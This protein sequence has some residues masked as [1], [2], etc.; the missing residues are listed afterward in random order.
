MLIL[1]LLDSK[2]CFRTFTVEKNK[3]LF[4]K[5]IFFFAT[6]TRSPPEGNDMQK[7]QKPFSAMEPSLQQCALNL[8]ERQWQFI[9]KL[10]CAEHMI[11]CCMQMI[12]NPESTLQ[13]ENFNFDGHF[14][15]IEV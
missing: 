2:Q 1:E 13:G 5:N 9:E 12:S 8:R 6:N 7:D 4:R 3:F 15:E 10:L 14:T 11:L